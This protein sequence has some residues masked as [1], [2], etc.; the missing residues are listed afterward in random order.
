MTA[1][2]ETLRLYLLHQ[3][4]AG[5]CDTALCVLSIRGHHHHHHHHRVR[6]SD[7]P[8]RVG[9]SEYL[10]RGITHG[11]EWWSASPSS[12]RRLFCWQRLH[13]CR[14]SGS[15]RPS[16]TWYGECGRDVLSIRCTRYHD[17]RWR[18]G[19]SLCYRWGVILTK[20]FVLSAMSFVALNWFHCRFS[21]FTLSTRW[22]VF[23]RRRG[24]GNGYAS[25]AVTNPLCHCLLPHW[26]ASQV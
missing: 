15:P 17:H 16:K 14:F 11:S 12:C 10:S 7:T 2:S 20:Q 23:K 24:R 1:I 6:V 18:K 4:C 3:R 8:R 9:T 5:P 13:L 26:P 21:P 19:D 22:C 25:A